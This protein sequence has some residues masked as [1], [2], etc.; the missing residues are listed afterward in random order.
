MR[1]NT[2]PRNYI[3]I[4]S[5]LGYIVPSLL[6]TSNR[7]LIPPPLSEAFTVKFSGIPLGLAGGLKPVRFNTCLICTSFKADPVQDQY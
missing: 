1:L 5:T 2:F 7:Y 6:G 3:S 4:T